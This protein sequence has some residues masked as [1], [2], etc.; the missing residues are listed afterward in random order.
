MPEK[1]NR[2]QHIA[3]S[4][5]LTV[6]P[7]SGVG[8]CIHSQSRPQYP[9]PVTDEELPDLIDA[10]QQYQDQKKRGR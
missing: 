6:S 10:L 8:L 3:V 7:W 1:K 9:T 4:D 2:T 5:D